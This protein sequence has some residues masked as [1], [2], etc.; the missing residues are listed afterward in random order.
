M[1][2]Y[3]FV[4][5]LSE[6]VPELP[7]DGIV[8]RTFFKNEQV[9]V[10]VFGFDAGQEL[11]EHTSSHP[12]ILHFVQGE[13]DLTLGDQ[14]MQAVPGT[15]VYMQPHLPHSVVAQTPVI[16]LLIMLQTGSV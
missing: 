14:Q 6:L 4:S 11:S 10:L 16:M 1:E 7:K 8:S 13:A 15:W 5:R 9:K 2:P 12:A 3:H